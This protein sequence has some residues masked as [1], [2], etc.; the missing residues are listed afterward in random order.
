MVLGS[1][2]FLELLRPFWHLEENTNTEPR[3]EQ[4]T[5]L[6]WHFGDMHEEH[7]SLSIF[8]TFDFFLLIYRK[9][10]L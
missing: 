3:E 5:C 7:E 1:S 10:E 9:S 6:N 4:Y 8:V 2:F